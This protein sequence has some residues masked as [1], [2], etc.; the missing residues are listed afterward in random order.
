MGGAGLSDMPGSSRYRLRRIVTPVLVAALLGLAACG[1][2]PGEETGGVDGPTDAVAR[3]NLVVVVVDDMDAV[4]M[5]L[6]DALPRTEELL[7]DR[8]TTFTNAF[9]PDP[10]CC[11]ARSTLL[12]GRY[13]HNTGVLLE[14]PLYNGYLAF[15]DSGNEADTIATRLRG[16]GYQTA[17]IGKYLN[18]YEEA[19]E[20][21]PPGW[22]DWFAVANGFHDG[23]DYDVN[24]NGVL[25]TRGDADDDYVTDALADEAVDFLAGTEGRD[26]DPF[27]LFLAPT[28]PHDAIPPARRDEG[29]EF[30]DDELPT[31]PNFDE[32]DVSDKPTWLRETV[33]PATQE[34]ILTL[35]RQYRRMMGS[36]L[37]VDD[38]VADVADQLAATGELDSTLFVLTSD[39]G[40][41][42]GAHRLIHKMA[43]YEESIRVPWV[44]AGPGV[45]HGR[46]DAMV[47]HTDLVPT[48]LDY[49]GV[50]AP[51]ASID[52]E[53][54]RGL[55]EGTATTWR[56]D[57]VVEH[58]GTYN[59]FFYFHTMEDIRSAVAM[60]REVMVPTYRGL[61][62]ETH[63]FVRW[64]AGDEHELE[65][66]DLEA[67]PW[68]LHNLLATPEGAAEHADLVAEL[69]GRLAELETCAGPSCRTT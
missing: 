40:F 44:M 55:L 9:A 37:A 8:G 26:D 54:I 15:G 64:Y 13:A 53:S 14:D 65:L 30:A 61:R 47:L 31:N 32:T 12:T 69:E 41:N 45:P 22:D 1:D 49:A 60:G 29:N 17:F 16:A 51:A 10:L 43:P 28:A 63:L 38:L 27:L 33:P 4:A 68:Q 48:L 35:Q 5:P 18:G 50:D 62:T 67:D 3:P 21:V 52:G 66:Y 34:E 11:P 56:S 59:P 20:G 2:G 23:Y 24:H 39:N 46:E 19:P 58:N 7:A 6:W 36:M 57:F 25:I 42:F